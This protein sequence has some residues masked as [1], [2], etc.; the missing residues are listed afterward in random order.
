MLLK[1]LGKEFGLT[2]E[3]RKLKSKEEKEEK[4]IQYIDIMWAA[5][6][7][8]YTG[9]AYDA[10]FCD[11]YLEEYSEEDEKKNREDMKLLESYQNII[12]DSI[13]DSKNNERHCSEKHQNIIENS[14]KSTE[15]DFLACVGRNQKIINKEIFS[16]VLGWEYNYD[17]TKK[18]VTIPNRK[19]FAWHILYLF[20]TDFINLFR[21]KNKKNKE[22]EERNKKNVITYGE[23]LQ[24]YCNG[25]QYGYLYE[26]L[27]GV[28]LAL[29]FMNYYM[30]IREQY[31]KI[32]ESQYKII[33][34]NEKNTACSEDSFEKCYEIV[35][36]TQGRV[37]R[38]SQQVKKW[39]KKVNE[40]IT[41]ELEKTRRLLQEVMEKLLEQPMAYV[42]IY[43]AS[44]DLEKISMELMGRYEVTPRKAREILEEELKKLLQNQIMHIG[45]EKGDFYGE[46]VL[47]AMQ[48]KGINM[49]NFI[50]KM[51]QPSKEDWKEI[52][53]ALNISTKADVF[54]EKFQ[55]KIGQIEFDIEL[56][57]KADM[58]PIIFIKYNEVQSNNEVWDEVSHFIID[59][60]D[61]IYKL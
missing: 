25:T 35:L 7:A 21:S 28:N 22:Q 31:K 53:H 17:K 20:D 43:K 44:K 18:I 56:T 54:D 50:K 55:E 13:T 1:E 14:P 27:T 34:D 5:Y 48:S 36:E 6:I 32:V 38:G 15:V 61:S 9:E 57:R 8:K 26:K 58:M 42:R 60:I 59:A 16:S 41:G 52:Q 23:K 30:K 46:E 3:L 24:K 12:D 37:V 47:R 19:F 49:D 39:K 51:E 10:N 4:I 2:K 33:D 11:E 29:V 45:K 40:E